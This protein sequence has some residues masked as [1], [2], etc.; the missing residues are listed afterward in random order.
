[1]ETPALPPA[2][3]KPGYKT[4]EFWFTVASSLVGLLMASG[5][6]RTGSSWDQ[7]I[8]LIATVLTTMG[9]QAARTAAKKG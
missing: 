9:Y 7:I 4:S 5:V 8:G 2:A 1:M 6:I 3:A